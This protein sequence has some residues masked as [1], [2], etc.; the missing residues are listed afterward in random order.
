MELNISQLTKLLFLNPPQ[1]PC[2]FNIFPLHTLSPVTHDSVM[3]PIL[4]NI[5]VDGAYILFGESYPS[6]ISQSQ[7]DTLKKYIA[8]IG[9]H[10]SS[11]FS[12]F[13]DESLYINI[14]F[15]PIKVLFDCHGHKKIYI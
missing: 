1:P 4:M 13:D 9:Y 15:K 2:S 6:N 7:F 5:L 11:S 12:S 3:F 10:I 14:W 8:S